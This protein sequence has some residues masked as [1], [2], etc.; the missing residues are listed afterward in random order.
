MS[1]IR[2][3]KKQAI[4]LKNQVTA[5]YYASQHP[6]LPLLARILIA[7]T[8]AYALSPIDLIPDFIPVLGYLDDLIILPLLISLSIR[9]IPEQIM[10]ESKKKSETQPITL[11]KNRKAGAIVILIWVSVLFILIYH[12]L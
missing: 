11:K 12:I 9:S 5:L 4:L 6:D 10:H 7:S 1:I 2:K 3:L 8:I